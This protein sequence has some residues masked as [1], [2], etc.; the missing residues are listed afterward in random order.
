MLKAFKKIILA[1]LILVI[2]GGIALFV[3]KSEPRLNK[4]F[5]NTKSFLKNHP[6]RFGLDLS[7]GTHLIYKADTSVVPA[8]QVGDSM[9][10][11]R[12]IIERRVNLFGVSEPARGD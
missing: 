4:N 3:F 1:L 10:A 5:A 12:D 9:A 6:F 2:G 7:G 8:T 11:L